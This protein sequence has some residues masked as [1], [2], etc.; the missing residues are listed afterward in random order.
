MTEVTCSD[1]GA[2]RPSWLAETSERPPCPACGGKALTI[3]VSIMET[4]SITDHHS[5]ELVPANQTRDWRQR[6]ELVQSELRSI[7]SPHT[8]AM[9]GESIHAALHQLCSFFIHA[10]HLK[11]AL[12]EEAFGLGLS[13]SDIERTI[14]D[15]SRLSLLA[16]LANLDKH[17]NLNR[18]PRSGSVPVVEQV[19]G[20]DSSS[21][22]GWYLVAKIKHGES[23]LGG[24]DVARNVVSAWQEKLAAWGLD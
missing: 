10:Y 1:C 15:D 23:V 2:S 13:P 22:D 19:S 5:V 7:V 21:S 14:S 18:P 20:S 3:G 6:W 8:E 11:D 4:L 17:I 9:S 16:D 12:K 24:L